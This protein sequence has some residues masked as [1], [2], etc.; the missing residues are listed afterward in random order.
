MSR[1]RAA[2]A[3][4]VALVAIPASGQSTCDPDGVQASGSIY[5][6][7]MPPAAKYNGNLI[8]WAHGF[9]DAGTPVSIPEDQLCLPEGLC[10]NEIANGLGNGFATNSYSKTGLAIVQGA[11]DIL[12][13]VNVYTAAKGKP[14]K[15]FLVG[16]S[17]G[18]IITALNVERRP[19]VFAAG[20]SICG[21][22]GSFPYQINYFGD[23]RATFEYFYPGIIPGDPFNP[24]PWL[25]SNWTLI[26]DQFVKPI[27]M[28]PETRDLL[29]QW[30][31]VAQLPYDPADF[32]ATVAK[33]AR[34]VLRYSVV[35]LTDA[36]ATLGGFPYDNTAKW[37]SGSNDDFLLNM[38]VPR[39][40][41]DASALAEMA[42]NYTTSGALQ[43]P[44]ITMHTSGDQQVPAWH[45]LIYTVKTANAG[46]LFT[47]HFP[48]SVNRYG[49]CNLTQEELIQ[50]FITMIVYEGLFN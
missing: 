38:N 30:V 50:G 8:I 34:D 28:A 25:V 20:L 40:S 19:D 46:T 1:F 13:L 41:A 7:C 27:I 11:A 44:L 3:A 33:S 42:A 22:I 21:P 15:V 10:L 39:R 48:I 9:Q 17:E 5:R 4:I 24:E 26:Y 32:E 18:G 14:N 23:A 47:R 35:N 2:L 12:D 36:T 43:Q 16:A 31:A 37:Y 49:H 45:Q 6:I 29:N